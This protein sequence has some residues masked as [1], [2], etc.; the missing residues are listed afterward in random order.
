L[1]GSG[2]VTGGSGLE[3]NRWL[4]PGDVVELEI[5]GIGLLSNRVVR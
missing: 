3:L 1:W 5:E 2:T 4:Q